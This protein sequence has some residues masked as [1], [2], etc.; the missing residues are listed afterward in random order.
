VVIVTNYSDLRARL[1]VAIQH[2]A[3]LG[4][5]VAE[6]SGGRRQ[7]ITT[8]TTPVGKT[9][10]LRPFDRVKAVNVDEVTCLNIFILLISRAS[11]STGLCRTTFVSR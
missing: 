3:E 11:H 10:T 2:V 5:R 8:P 4:Q 9:S 7:S 6:Q 1:E